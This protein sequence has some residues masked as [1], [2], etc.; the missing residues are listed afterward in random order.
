LWLCLALN[1]QDTA[2]LA[3]P[4]HTHDA[5][6]I[7]PADFAPFTARRRG[8]MLGGALSRHAIL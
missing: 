7:A 8:G 3:S 4:S 6:S 1:G 5:F 2:A